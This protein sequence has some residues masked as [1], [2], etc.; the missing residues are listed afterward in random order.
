MVANYFASKYQTE[1][2]YTVNGPTKCRSNKCQI[3]DQHCNG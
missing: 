2:N 3:M 1:E